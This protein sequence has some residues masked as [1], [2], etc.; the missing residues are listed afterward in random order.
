ME[1]ADVEEQGWTPERP[2]AQGH[3][4][5]SEPDVRRDEAAV[6]AEIQRLLDAVAHRRS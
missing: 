4:L 2:E 1:G 3:V 6:P 5:A